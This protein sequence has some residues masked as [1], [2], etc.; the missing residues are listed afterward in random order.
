MTFEELTILIGMNCRSIREKKGLS[1]QTVA[2]LM[3]KNRTAAVSDF[4]SGK[5]N[6]TLLTISQ[7]AEALEVDILDLLNFE[8]LRLGEVHQDHLK[9]KMLVSILQN[10]NSNEIDYITNI[11]ESFINFIDQEQKIAKP[12]KNPPQS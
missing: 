8:G 9:L 11:A 2:E 1:Q 5:T 10:R 7:F 12:S 6:P 4:E 3:E